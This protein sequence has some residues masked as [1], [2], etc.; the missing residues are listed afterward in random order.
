MSISLF[1]IKHA[2]TKKPKVHCKC[3]FEVSTVSINP[4]VDII[5]KN[6]ILGYVFSF[7]LDYKKGTIAY[8][9]I[10]TNFVDEIGNSKKNVLH[11]IY[12]DKSETYLSTYLFPKTENNSIKISELAIKIV[13]LCND[14]TIFKPQLFEEIFVKNEL[15][16]ALQKQGRFVY[17]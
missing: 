17:E 9:M 4:I 6:K 10:E 8:T 15:E 11:P 1:G 14:A 5:N 3:R 7:K 16:L 13:N 2:E 12:N